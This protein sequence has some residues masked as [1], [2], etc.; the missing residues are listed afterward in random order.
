MKLDV[1]TPQQLV[2]R[3][4]FG[5]IECEL[6]HKQPDHELVVI[7]TRFAVVSHADTVVNHGKARVVGLGRAAYF[8]CFKVAKG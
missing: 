5:R 2:A 1:A 8:P 4:E 3:I 7:D 6:K